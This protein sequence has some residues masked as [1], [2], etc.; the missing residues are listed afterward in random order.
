[1]VY[2]NFIGKEAFESDPPKPISNY[3]AAKLSGEVLVRG[4]SSSYENFFINYKAIS[5][6]WAGDQNLR[7]LQKFIDQGFKKGKAKVNGKDLVLDFTYIDDICNGFFLAAE[8]LNSEE[9]PIFEIINCTSG[10]PV[11]LETAT[12]LIMKYF[13]DLQVDFLPSDPRVPIRGGLNLKKAKCFLGYTPRY[14]FEEGLAEYI[15]IERILNRNEKGR[16]KSR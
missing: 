2:G 6:I 10:D 7:V 16:F 5:C 3:G 12:N 4:F 11:S 13:P 8:K 14:K 9:K 15:N 1:M